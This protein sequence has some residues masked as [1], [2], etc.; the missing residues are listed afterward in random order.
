MFVVVVAVVVII[1]F[2]CFCFSEEVSVI[3]ICVMGKNI[4][5]SVSYL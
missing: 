5:L 1:V 4:I 3:L 2:C